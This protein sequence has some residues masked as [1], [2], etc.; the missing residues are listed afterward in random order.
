MRTSSIVTISLPPSLVRESEKA[1][2][3]QRMTRSELLRMALRHYLEELQLE[4][5]LRV[6][7]RELAA[8]KSKTLPRGG[9]ASIMRT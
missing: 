7:E 1:A 3:R 8:G 4:E 9:L 5:A 6:A 2:R